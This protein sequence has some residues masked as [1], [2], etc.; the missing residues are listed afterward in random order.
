MPQLSFEIIAEYIKRDS[1]S[2]KVR[3]INDRGV[4]STK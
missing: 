2:M 3:R 4:F 1:Q